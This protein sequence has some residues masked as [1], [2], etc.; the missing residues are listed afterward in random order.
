MV[1]GELPRLCFPP[2]LQVWQAACHFFLDC[3][4]IYTSWKK[5]KSTKHGFKL[6]IKLQHAENNQKR[7]EQIPLPFCSRLSLL[8][9]LM[10]TTAWNCSG[11]DA[12]RPRSRSEEGD[13]GA[14]RE[15]EGPDLGRR[16]PTRSHVLLRR[17]MSSVL[18]RRGRR[19]WTPKSCCKIK[20]K[21]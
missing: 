10:N 4:Q 2:L 21:Y 3:K 16:P 9:R 20:I 18:G 14:D 17:L 8:V 7:K 11:H 1:V 13:E 12:R 19:R 6:K 15:E 5:E